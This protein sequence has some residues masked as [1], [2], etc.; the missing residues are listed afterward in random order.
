M[1]A[2]LVSLMYLLYFTLSGQLNQTEGFLILDKGSAFSI[3]FCHFLLY[4]RN[5]K[6]K[7]TKT[8]RL[9]GALLLMRRVEAEGR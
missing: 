8:R 6:Q 4:N 7:I 2:A 9:S 1:P 5:P 3:R